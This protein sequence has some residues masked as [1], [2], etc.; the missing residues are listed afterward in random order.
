M[1]AGVLA[2]QGGFREHARA[3]CRLG[4]SCR[5]VRLPAHFDG[6]E[7]LIVPG[8]ESTTIAKLA[9]FAAYTVLYCN[10]VL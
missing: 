2:L 7:G 4:V 9:L 10:Y 6:L 5:E 8:G 1:E 3:L